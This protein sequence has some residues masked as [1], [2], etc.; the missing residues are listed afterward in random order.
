[1]TEQEVIVDLKEL[2][3][4][5]KSFLSGEPDNDEIF[6]RDITALEAA[7][8]IVKSLPRPV[9]FDGEKLTAEYTVKDWRKKLKEEYREVKQAVAEFDF[10]LAPTN[11]EKSKAKLAEEL[12]DVITV[13]TSWLNA[14]GYDEK[15]RAELQRKVNEKNAERGYFREGNE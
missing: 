2:V 1:M 11:I 14:F 5:R 12:T 4:D 8:E 13:C 7:I 15:A 10:W 6:L 9:T 3:K